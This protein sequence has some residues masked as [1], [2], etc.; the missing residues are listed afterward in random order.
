MLQKLKNNIPANCKANKYKDMQFLPSVKSD[1]G[2]IAPQDPP[3][4][5]AISIMTVITATPI[6]IALIEMNIMIKTTN[7]IVMTNLEETHFF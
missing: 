3:E 1:G 5:V 2:K 4:S 6:I 7:V